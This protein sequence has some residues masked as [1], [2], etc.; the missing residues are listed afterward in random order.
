MLCLQKQENK[1]TDTKQPAE[2]TQ[3]TG[4]TAT[5]LPTLTGTKREVTATLRADSAAT[6]T[7][8]RVTIIS[9]YINTFVPAWHIP[10]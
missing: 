8:Q 5:G 1:R 4:R 9:A 10:L 6:C 3:E 2:V 7:A